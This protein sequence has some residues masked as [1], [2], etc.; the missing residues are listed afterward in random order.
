MICIA[1]TDVL[2]LATCSSALGISYV[3]HLPL[4]DKSM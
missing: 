1:D 4:G 2:I 3:L